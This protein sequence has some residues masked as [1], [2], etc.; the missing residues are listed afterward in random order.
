MSFDRREFLKLAGGGTRQWVRGCRRELRLGGL[1]DL[2][3]TQAGSADA[4][5]LGGAHHAGAHRAQ[6]HVPA[7]LA[8]VVGVTDLVAEAR[9]LAAHIT[10]SCHKSPVAGLKE[11]IDFIRARATAPMRAPE[12]VVGQVPDSRL[13]GQVHS[14]LQLG[15]PILHQH[16]RRG[17]FQFGCHIDEEAPIGC[18]VILAGAESC[19]SFGGPSNGS[20]LIA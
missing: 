5:T 13:H 1:D 17:A 18:N 19:R 2:A 4:Q 7:A 6:V 15:R 11:S 3:A 20:E 12:K 14:F 9:P 8:H 16:R 10:H